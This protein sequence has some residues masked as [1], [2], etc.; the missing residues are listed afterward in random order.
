[1]GPSSYN[2][3]LE[4]N[5]QILGLGNLNPEALVESLNFKFLD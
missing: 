2:P 3:Y 1:M 4:V 5:N